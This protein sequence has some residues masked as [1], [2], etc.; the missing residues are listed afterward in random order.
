[1]Q[2]AISV[3][4]IFYILAE[5]PTSFLV[6][7]LQFNRVIPVIIFCWG[8]VCL[9][10]GFISSFGP[11]VITRILLGFFEGCLFPSM[12]LFLCN[13]YKREELAVRIAYLFSKY[14]AFDA[15]DI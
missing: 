4:Y 1:M 3:F 5:F 7:R 13:W 12:T 9:F 15:P 6:K 8:V 10:T 2:T 11:L 14:Y